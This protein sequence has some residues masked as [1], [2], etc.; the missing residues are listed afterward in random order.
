MSLHV[1]DHLGPESADFDKALCFID[2][3]FVPLDDAKISVRDLGLT[4]ADMTYDVLH[5]WKGK[6]FQLDAH[7]NR[8]AESLRGFRLDPGYSREDIVAIMDDGLTRAGLKDALVYFA[9]TRGVPPRGSRDLRAARPTFFASITPLIL[10]GS[11]AEMQRGLHLHIAQTVKRIPPDSINPVWKNV[12]WGDLTTAQY[13]AWEHGRDSVV[14]PGHDGFLTEGPG[15]NVMAIIDGKLVTPDS[16]AL[17]GIARRTMLELA[18]ELGIPKAIVKITAEELRNADEAFITS[19]SC[20]LFP[21]TRI[22]GRYISNG[23]PGPLTTR[24]YNGYI[25]RKDAGWRGTP[26]R[27]GRRFEKSAAAAS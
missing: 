21:V 12:H 5:V 26:V 6:Y 4:H 25:E 23:A 3:A 19:T 1:P 10:R 16:G 13:E 27:Y 7:M 2:G 24:L 18:D 8:F 22:D 17:E 11:P 14:L 9:C 15:Y 20:G